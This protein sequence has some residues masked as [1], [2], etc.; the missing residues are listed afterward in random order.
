[1]SQTFLKLFFAFASNLTDALMVRLDGRGNTVDDLLDRPKADGNSQHGGEQLLNDGA[2]VTLPSCHLSHSGTEPWPLA[3]A[4]FVRQGRLVAFAATGAMGAVEI[5]VGEVQFD[6][7]QLDV[8]VRRD[9]GRLGKIMVTAAAHLGLERM[10]V[11]R[12]N[13]SAPPMPPP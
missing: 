12:K 9:R 13:P 6:L 7:R 10:D 5:E 3:C 2:T 8:R 11:P 1:M 4:V